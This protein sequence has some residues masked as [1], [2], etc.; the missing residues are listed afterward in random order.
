[1]SR[2]IAEMLGFNPPD[3]AVAGAETPAPKGAP[4]E[5]AQAPTADDLAPFG[6][7]PRQPQR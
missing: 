7:S 4:I 6:F 5:S 2:D 3:P 1:L